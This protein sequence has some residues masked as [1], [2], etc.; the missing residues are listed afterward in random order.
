MRKSLVTLALLFV[1]IL[2]SCGEY[3]N[4]TYRIRSGDVITVTDEYH[5]C[6]SEPTYGDRIYVECFVHGSSRFPSL[7]LIAD[8]MEVLPNE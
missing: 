5:R 1:I 2:S 6:S 7:S 8:T 3:E 4:P